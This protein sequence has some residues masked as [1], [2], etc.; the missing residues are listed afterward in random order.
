MTTQTAA[1]INLNNGVEMPILGLGVFQSP[2]EETVTAVEAAI[3]D[4][5]RLI[6]TAAAYGNEREVGDGLRRSGIDRVQMFVTTKLWISDYGYEQALVGFDGCLRRLGLDYVDLFLLHHPVP[7]DFASTVGAYKAAEKMLAEGRARAIGV[8]NF[9]SAHLENLISQ[10]SVVPAV[11]QVE[12]HPFFIQQ[13]LRDFHS[14]HG[15]VTQAWSPL[16]GVN[17]YRPADA[18]AVENP[19]EH[20]TIVELASKYGKT[21]AQVVLRWHIEHG[22]SAIP[23]SVRPHRIKENFDVFDFQLTS[24]EV[25]AIDA[26]DTGVRGGPEPAGISPATYAY[27]VEND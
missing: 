22:T 15:I 9:S 21:P 18:G 17:R 25:A 20:P 19:L 24:D 5:Y 2:P 6:D 11:N 14:A 13:T 23:K 3:D 16:G 1:L 27:K 26:L 12:L 4:G 10:T 8:S 7:T